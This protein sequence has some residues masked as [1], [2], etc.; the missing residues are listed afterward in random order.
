MSVID[1]I[2][3]LRTPIHREGY[4][5]IGTFALV[6]ILLAVLWAPL[7]WIGLIITCWCIYFFRNPER[8]IPVKDGLVVAPGD[9]IVSEVTEALPPAELN[10]GDEPLPRISIF[11]NVFNVHVNRIPIGG[12]VTRIHYHP[13]KFF[14]A[15]LDK[16]SIHNERNSVIVTTDGLKQVIFVQIAGLVARRIVCYLKEEQRVETG[17]KYGLIRFGS[18]V[19][20]YLPKGVVPLVGKKQVIVGGET[21]LA[22]LESP[23]QPHYSYITR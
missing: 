4:I 19:D 15:D 18:R 5:F 11:L 21:V 3:S 9:G 1:S 14:S 6:T 16:A 17:E 7:G 10:I 12:I 23:Q 22:D 2:K 20:V 13:G 8:V